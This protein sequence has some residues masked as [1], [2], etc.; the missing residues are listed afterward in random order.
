MIGADNISDA[1]T[2]HCYSAMSFRLCH[3]TCCQTHFCH[4]RYYQI[5]YIFYGVINISNNSL[6]YNCPEYKVCHNYLTHYQ[7]HPINVLSTILVIGHIVIFKGKYLYSLS[8]T[9]FCI[10]LS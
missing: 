6:T 2:L 1:V 8:F 7:C 9:C 5:A 10:I 4:L 3:Q